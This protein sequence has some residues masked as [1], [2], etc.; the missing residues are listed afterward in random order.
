MKLNYPKE[1]I[2]NCINSTMD[3]IQ[4]QNQSTIL[5]INHIGLCSIIVQEKWNMQIL[6]Q[7][8]NEPKR[9]NEIEKVINQ[10]NNLDNISPKI[11]SR[12]LKQLCDQNLIV[13]Y[14]SPTV[15]PSVHY[16]ITELGL[17]Y[18]PVLLAMEE[19]GS[20]LPGPEMKIDEF[21]LGL[22]D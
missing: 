4:N 18:S 22:N 9:Y 5:S 7:L 1:T 8:I 3:I 14:R 21:D 6:F 12:R 16:Q 2:L 11:L 13:K 19:V 10:H 17:I 15:P 20:L